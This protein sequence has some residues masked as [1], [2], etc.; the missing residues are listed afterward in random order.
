MGHLLSI[1]LVL[2]LTILFGLLT[3]KG[4]SKT[5]WGDIEGLKSLKKGVTSTSIT[6]GS[7][8]SSW[9]FSVDPCDNLFSSK[10]SCGFR[11]DLVITGLKR[12]TDINLD[13][14]GYTGS[15]SSST[16]TFPYLE[17]L[18]FTD[19]SFTG[20]IPNSL[21]NLGRLRKLFLS[22][23]SFSGYI[24]NSIGAS[25]T[26]LEELYLDNNHLQG[27]IP[28]NFNNLVSLKRLGLHQNKLNGW[29]PNLS[30]LKNLVFID[31]SNN[32]ISG[33]IPET[34]PS[35]LVQILMR[36]NYLTGTLPVSLSHMGSLQV[37]DLSH[38]LLSG[39]VSSVF[40]HPSLQQVT[41]SHNKFN[42][43][44]EPRNL[45]SELLALD[46]SYN[47][48]HG[49]LP[50]FMAKM[51]KISAL[52]LEKNKL[53]GMIHPEY[54]IKTVSPGTGVSPF[55]RLLLGGNYLHGPIPRPLIGL[56][57]GSAVVSLIDNCLFRCPSKLFFCRGGVQKSLM[58]CKNLSP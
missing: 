1:E 56:K 6:P 42:S 4:E 3:S 26:Q 10:F 54:A 50:V 48:L 31:V 14:A 51:Q 47:D 40:D 13:R 16:F 21:S 32:L 58:A 29:I 5:Y 11:C 15:I 57:P 12:V 55:V 22:G 8:L 17:T 24:P 18:D 53:T 45:K 43:L 7:C 36:N 39:T 20:V 44:Q 41:L 37:I 35:T 2:V 34:L 25:L 46:I 33:R 23:N 27:S 52:S 49:E 38:N 28:V 30:A 9:D 19:N